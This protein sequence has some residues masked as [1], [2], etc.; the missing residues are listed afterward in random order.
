MQC[1]FDKREVLEEYKQV[2]TNS[3]I[4]DLSDFV[5]FR[6]AGKDA[7]DFL[8]L[9]LTN[10]I[11]E[12][13]HGFG[14]YSCLC[15]KKG[16]ILADLYCYAESDSFL[17]EC[18]KT[19]KDKIQDLLKRYIII[20]DVQIGETLGWKGVGVIGPKSGSL[21]VSWGL[22]PPSENLQFDVISTPSESGGRDLHLWLIRKNRWGLDGFEIWQ[23]GVGEELF[24]EERMGELFPE[25]S[26]GYAVA[27]A[28][29]SS[30]FSLQDDFSDSLSCS[31]STSICASL[32]FSSAPTATRAA[33]RTVK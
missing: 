3:G 24:E 6:I 14:C 20:E 2:T 32:S 22:K 23:Q 4:L 1:R 16:K 9:I 12:L 21:L 18:D 30:P 8:N 13:C 19:L 5:C 29:N 28:G 27:S 15:D 31:V 7:R 10:N 25:A 33:E 11:K 26:I 17:I